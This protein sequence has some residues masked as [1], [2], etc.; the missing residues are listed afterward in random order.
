MIH[1]AIAVSTKAAA[2]NQKGELFLALAAAYVTLTTF[3]TM[4]CGAV[5]SRRAGT[6]IAR[7]PVLGRRPKRLALAVA[8]PTATALQGLQICRDKLPTKVDIYGAVLRRVQARQGVALLWAPALILDAASAVYLTDATIST[9]LLFVIT[10]VVDLSLDARSNARDHIAEL[11]VNAVEL[12]LVPN[13]GRRGGG[14]PTA[15]RLARSVS[16]VCRAID[17]A[18]G[19]GIPRSERRVR[20][21]ATTAS[22]RLVAQLRYSSSEFLA[23][24]AD[25]NRRRLAELLSSVLQR[26]A[27]H[28]GDVYDLLPVDPTLI[29]DA[30]VITMTAQPS[31]RD[32][33]GW[34]W[35]GWGSF[36]I[37]VATV[38]LGAVRLGLPVEAQAAVP[39]VFTAL[40]FHTL[41][42][43]GIPMLDFPR[44]PWSRPAADK[45]SGPK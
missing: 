37:L 14:E 44:M 31:V 38:W 28:V 33:L 10:V 26:H 27:A 17:R 5:G 18:A 23:G 42:R 25:D 8:E 32:G 7:T 21:A 3:A 1:A 39:A 12:L 24:Q 36:A 16:L 45:L 40:G 4:F 20:N 34:V 30:E 2:R 22:A 35:A 11:T 6:W 19:F 41:K 29:N 15:V 13:T 9:I 43:L